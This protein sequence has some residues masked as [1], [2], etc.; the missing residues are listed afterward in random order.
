MAVIPYPPYSPGLAPCDYFFPFPKMK[1]KL[2]GHWF[3]TIEEIQ[4]ESQGACHSYGKGF[5]G[6]VPKMEATVGSV[7]TCGRE[8]LR[9]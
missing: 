7:S 3:D 5:S 6:S 4:A 2:K 1:L 9:G 8:P